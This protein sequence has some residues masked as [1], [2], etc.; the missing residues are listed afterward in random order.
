MIAVNLLK[1]YTFYMTEEKWAEVV[2]HIKDNFEVLD[3]Y[4][5]DYAGGIGS[6]E[7][8]EVQHDLGRIR[9]IYESLP[10][11]LGSSALYSKRGNSVTSVKDS[12]DFNDIIHM[13]RLELFNPK[14]GDWSEVSGEIANL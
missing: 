5:E 11:K 8:Y 2:A 1:R 6:A 4:L 12:Y 13:F 3:H 9:F 10:R 14:T 7:I